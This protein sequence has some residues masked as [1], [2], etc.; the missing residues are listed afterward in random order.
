MGISRKHM[1]SL[2]MI[3]IYLP[4]QHFIFRIVEVTLLDKAMTLDRNKLFELG[5]VSML[6]FRYSWLADINAHLSC[7][8]RM[9]Q[10]R[11]R[12]SLIHVHLQIKS[13]FL[14]RQVR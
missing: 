13:G 1:Y 12:T 5:V 9:N 6:S 14:I 4:F 11:E 10:L 2:N 7:I 3:A 8:Q